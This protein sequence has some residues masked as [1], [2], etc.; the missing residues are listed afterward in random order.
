MSNKEAAL[1]DADDSRNVLRISKFI[2]SEYQVGESIRALEALGLSGHKILIDGLKTG[3]AN[4]SSKLI[5]AFYTQPAASTGD[6]ELALRTPLVRVVVFAR[7]GPAVDLYGGIV[8]L[9]RFDFL[10]CLY[11]NLS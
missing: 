2:D 7:G 1:A 11:T 6:G 9:I 8:S 3:T 4:V 5:D 10:S